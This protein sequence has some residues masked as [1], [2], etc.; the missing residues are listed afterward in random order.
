[1]TIRTKVMAVLKT[2]VMIHNMD[3][4]K[5]IKTAG[6]VYESQNS[7]NVID[8]FHI[9]LYS[10]TYGFHWDCVKN[11]IKSVPTLRLFGC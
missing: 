1:M 11:K 2:H 10:N 7:S 9:K 4:D 5:K 8:I 3:F 6:F